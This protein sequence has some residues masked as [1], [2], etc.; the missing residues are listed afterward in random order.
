MSIFRNGF[1]IFFIPGFTLSFG[2]SAISGIVTN[3]K[4]DALSFVNIGIKG[5]NIGTCSTS[6]GTFSI[7]IPENLKNDSVSL[8]LLG[9]KT[10]MFPISRLLSKKNMLVLYPDPITLNEVPV[11]AKKFEERKFGIYRYRS[12]LHFVDASIQQ[13]DIFEIAQVV[14]LPGSATKISSVNLFINDNRNDS[15]LFRINFYKLDDGKP[16]KKL[17]TQELFFKKSI[18]EGWLNFDLQKANIYLKG[19]VACAIEFI[20]FGKG[21]I[22][23][24]VKVGGTSKSFVR[25]SS[26][27]EWQIPPAHYKLFVTAFIDPLK[28]P[29]IEKDEEKQSPPTKVMYSENVK[30]SFYIFVSLPKNYSG[31]TTF[32]VTYVIDGNFYFDHLK[33]NSES[34]IVGIGYKNEYLSDSLRDRDYTYPKALKED[35]VLVSGGAFRFLDFI[36]KELIPFIDKNYRTD[37]SERRLMGHSLGGLFTLFALSQNWIDKNTFTEYVAASPSLH[38]HNR[39]LLGEF[40]KLR[41]GVTKSKTLWIT[42]GSEE[43]LKELPLLVDILKNTPVKIKSHVFPKMDHMETAVITF[44]EA[45]SDK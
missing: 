12:L 27:G 42:A 1:L 24:E 11:S 10:R 23:Y 44:K 31:K 37:P 34:I 40:E 3:E 41:T 33:G 4:G 7:S 19:T 32:P 5:K 29:A 45:L 9:Y 30:D 16:G 39:Y 17:N 35:S 18:R 6:E 26:F 8:A 20:P 2:Q 22:K 14:H 13:N 38:Y 43:D 25:T 28:V 15:G 21:V 36:E